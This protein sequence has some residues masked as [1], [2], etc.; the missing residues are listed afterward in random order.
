VLAKYAEIEVHAVKELRQLEDKNRRLKQ[1]VA[2]QTFVIQAR[3]AITEKYWYRPKRNKPWPSGWPSTSGGVS[4][5]SVGCSK[6]I[7]TRG[8]T[9]ERRTLW[10]RLSPPSG[11]APT[12]LVAKSESRGA[13][14]HLENTPDHR[15]GQAQPQCA[16]I[17]VAGRLQGALQGWK[18][19]AIRKCTPRQN[20]SV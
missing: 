10:S 8:G 3:K 19:E 18:N 1:M 16:G 2:E 15:A 6:W 12:R 20:R 5:A 4:D 7:G 11:S 9:A 13:G 14:H 17:A